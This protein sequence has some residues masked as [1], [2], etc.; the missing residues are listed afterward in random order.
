[1]GERGCMFLLICSFFSFEPTSFISFP[2]MSDVLFLVMLLVLGCKLCYHLIQVGR[3]NFGSRMLEAEVGQK[4]HVVVRAVTGTGNVVY[5][6]SDG[7]EVVDA[8]E[9]RCD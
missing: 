6:L 8:K 4:Y 3:R 5:G 1:M 9:V 7:F 2:A